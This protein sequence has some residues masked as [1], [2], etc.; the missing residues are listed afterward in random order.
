MQTSINKDIEKV[1]ERGTICYSLFSQYTTL[2]QQLASA[3]FIKMLAVVLHC[4]KNIF[5]CTHAKQ[6]SNT[7]LFNSIHIY[8][9]KPLYS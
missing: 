1:T 7:R 9:L 5:V 3:L 6:A 2:R 8:K 4:W